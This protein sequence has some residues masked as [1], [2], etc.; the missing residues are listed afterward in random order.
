MPRSPGRVPSA[1]ITPAAAV[2]T[3]PVRDRVVIATCTVL[4][5]L[6]A[7][8]YLIHLDRQMA[9]DLR[10]AQSMAE[11][12]MTMDMPCMSTDVFLTFAMW[13][14]M[15]VGMMA[16]SASPMILL[17]GA[18]RAGRG[19]RGVSMATLAFG[20]GYVAVWAGFSAAATLAQWG[21]HRAAMLSAAAMALSS[22]RLSGGV[23]IAAGVYQITTWKGSCLMHCRSP[24]GFLMT[25][26]RDGTGGAFGMGWRHGLYCLGCCWALM[27]VLFVVGVMNL[28][29]I[30]ALAVLVLIEKILPSGALAARLAGVALI[31]AG[32]LRLF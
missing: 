8:L 19:G 10:H 6:L 24:L 32:V 17:F 4:I 12:G 16:P 31:A 22:E 2:A 15:M 7:W 30:S 5:T 3:L 21:L 9:A 26:W 25:N 23:L 20:L 11:M 29:W 13:V 18:S 14:V 1:A 27:C 28:L